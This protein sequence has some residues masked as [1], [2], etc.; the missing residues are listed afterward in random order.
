[1]MNFVSDLAKGRRVLPA[2]HFP[3]IITFNLAVFLPIIGR[4]F[5]HDD[6]I[7]LYSATYDSFLSG[8]T[9]ATGGPF[10]APIAW[11][12][13][14]FDSFAWNGSPYPMAVENLMIHIANT[15]LLYYFAER[16]WLSKT[17][18]WWTAVGFTLLYPANT[19]AVMWISTRA[20]LLASFFTL[21]AM[22]MFVQ[23]TRS[24]PRR[25]LSGTLVVICGVGA[26]FSKESG[27]TVLGALAA[28][29]FYEKK[30]GA[31]KNIS[32]S[33][34]HCIFAALCFAASIYIILRSHSGA[35][36]LNFNGA[37][38]YT[39][40]TSPGVLLSNILHYGW[41]TYGLIAVLGGAILLS[42]YLRGCRQLPDKMI[43]TKLVLLFTLFALA[44]SPFILLPARSGIYTY[45][46]GAA[47][48]LLLG[49]IVRILPERMRIEKKST[50]FACTASIL[51]IVIIYTAF[52]IGHSLR[53]IQMAENTTTVL[54]QIATQ[55]PNPAPNEN[56]QLAYTERD[57][58]NRFPDGFAEWGFPYALKM[59]YRDPSLNGKIVQQ[60]NKPAPKSESSSVYFIYTLQEYKPLI[61]MLKII[62]RRPGN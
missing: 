12:T 19:W 56:F 37:T 26:I 35:V 17:A 51:F 39:Y 57:Q 49:A 13:F 2:Y 48:A 21:A 11:L 16:L 7:P 8:M 9:K 22:L 27:L 29:W 25:W 44:I 47:A 40:V 58:R 32:T 18:A 36:S 6:F 55:H 20:H 15:V 30:S 14:V 42:Q 1:M 3:A 50:N 28:L 4:G 61:S 52:T 62:S 46:P 33:A 60:N 24:K 54:H 38:G 53:W 59:L 41:R 10:Y 23:L 34:L 43:K 31:G 5:I 45:L